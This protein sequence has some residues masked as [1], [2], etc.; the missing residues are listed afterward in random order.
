[1][2][3]TGVTEMDTSSLPDV[4]NPEQLGNPEVDEQPLPVEYKI[5]GER[6][7]RGKPKLVDSLGYTY[8]LKRTNVDER[9][10]WRCSVRNNNMHCKATVQ[11]HKTVFRPGPQPHLHQP[12]QINMRHIPDDVLKADVQVGDVRFKLN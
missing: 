12:K 3:G 2:S 7:Q 6:T 4:S 8:V 5:S 1:M 9:S 11:Q 10:E